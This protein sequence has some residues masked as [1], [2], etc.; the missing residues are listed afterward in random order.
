M[1]EGHP[2]GPP[3]S[4]PYLGCEHVHHAIDGSMEHEAPDKVDDQHARGQRC[5]EIDHL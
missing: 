1:S 2:Q 4:S 3:H 5:S